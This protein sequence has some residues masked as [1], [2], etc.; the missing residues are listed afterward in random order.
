MKA[1]DEGGGM[2]DERVE[3]IAQSVDSM[4]FILHPSFLIESFIA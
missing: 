2:R 4:P 3:S 1:R